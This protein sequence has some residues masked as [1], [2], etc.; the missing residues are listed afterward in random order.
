MG[1]TAVTTSIDLDVPL[2]YTMGHGGVLLENFSP[3]GFLLRI[4]TTCCWKVRSDDLGTQLTTFTNS[5]NTAQPC[6][7]RR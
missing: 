5:P 2:D 4:V 3:K 7:R 1:G 6:G